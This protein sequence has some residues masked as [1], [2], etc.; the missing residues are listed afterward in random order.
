MCFPKLE[1]LRLPLQ[2]LILL[3][4]ETCGRTLQTS[5]PP[6]CSFQLEQRLISCIALFCIWESN[7]GIEYHRR[8]EPY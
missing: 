7:K 8:S 1:A 5:H 4:V 2:D 3:W 6:L